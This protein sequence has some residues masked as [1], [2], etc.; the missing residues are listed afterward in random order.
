MGRGEGVEAR[1]QGRLAVVPS[2]GQGWDSF[3]TGWFNAHVSRFALQFPASEVPGLAARF[4]Y[5]KDDSAC[6]EAGAAARERGRYTRDE[7]ILICTWKTARSKGRVAR[8]SEMEVEFATGRVFSTKDE[9]KRMEALTGLEGVGVPT[10]SALLYF[11]FPDDYP[12]LDVRALES[13][14]QRGRT[15]YPTDYW[16]EYLLACRRIATELGAPIRT[17]DK[18]LWQAS[19]ERD[20]NLL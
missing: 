3:T 2:P 7:L 12:I 5:P 18:A 17:L 11:A 15:I 16:T 10:G 4:S 1:T 13:L 9:D 19:K 14:G 8:N 20:A 6:L